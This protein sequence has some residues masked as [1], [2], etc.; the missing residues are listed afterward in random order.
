MRLEQTL[1]CAWYMGR[2]LIAVGDRFYVLLLF[3]IRALKL[4]RGWGSH[5]ILD[6]NSI[7]NIRCA[8]RETVV[9]W[10]Y[11]ATRDRVAGT[12]HHDEEVHNF[13]RAPLNIFQTAV[14]EN[15][16]IEQHLDATPIIC[17]GGHQL[18]CARLQTYCWKHNRKL[19]F[20]AWLWLIVIEVNL[21]KSIYKFL[22]Y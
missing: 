1:S 3:S 2:G 4:L 22:R 12:V 15:C 13:Y 19:P 6:P 7:D 20:K 21:Q 17:G 14:T 10:S 18:C 9:Q 8:F 5:Y 11:I 16:T